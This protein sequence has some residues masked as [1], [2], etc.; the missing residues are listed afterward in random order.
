MAR[1]TPKRDPTDMSPSGLRELVPTSEEQMTPVI[2]A[3]LGT[4]SG[5]DPIRP[6]EPNKTRPQ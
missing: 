1:G 2:L 4:I 6:C 5:S 3:Y